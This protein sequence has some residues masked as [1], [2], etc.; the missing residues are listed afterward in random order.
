MLR[1]D[2]GVRED[3]DAM[4]L[5]LIAY[6]LGGE[7]SSF[8]VMNN[9]VRVTLSALSAILGGTQVL[10]CSAIDEALGIPT[11]ETALLSLRTQQIIL[12]ESGIASFVDPLGES[13]LVEEMTNG[14]IAEAFEWD[15]RV[16]DQGG[17]A[18]AISSGWM[19]AQIDHSAWETELRRREH[20][21]VGEPS[22]NDPIRLLDNKERSLFEVNPSYESERSEHVAQMKSR[23]SQLEV[24]V[25]LNEFDRVVFAGENIV[26]ASTDA[27]LKGVTL[28][29]L[30]A[31]L[32]KKYGSVVP[33]LSPVSIG[34]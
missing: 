20:P 4:K 28:G 24:D 3:S 26:E 25:S 19:R 13:A 6:T 33:G 1:N 9:A 5:R 17:S 14:L 29:E 7:L 10:F 23:R 27:F 21:L 32:V 31:V 2:Y 34:R 16:T 8:E 11:D 30:M 12:E 18:L 15:E 22:A